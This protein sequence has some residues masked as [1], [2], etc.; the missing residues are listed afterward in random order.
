MCALA[1]TAWAESIQASA[2]ILLKLR[3]IFLRACESTLWH[4]CHLVTEP[5]APTM[6][7]P[8]DTTILIVDDEPANLTSLAKIFAK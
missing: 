7:K 2:E 4:T 6:R 8:Q 1:G 3:Q 5:G